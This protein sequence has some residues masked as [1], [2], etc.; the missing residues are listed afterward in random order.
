MTTSIKDTVLRQC[1]AILKREDVKTELKELMRP[2]IDLILVELYPY[3][4]LSMIFVFISF[5]LILGIFILLMRYKINTSL[6][7]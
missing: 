6:K 3:I 2:M 1:L 5:L 7:Y 4:F